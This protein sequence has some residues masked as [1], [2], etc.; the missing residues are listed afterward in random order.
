MKRGVGQG[1]RGAG[2]ATA[3][4]LFFAVGFGAGTVRS[5]ERTW[6]RSEIL[7]IADKEAQTSGYDIERM[8]ISLDIYNS[9]WREHLRTSERSGAIGEIEGKLK[10]RQYWAVYYSPLKERQLG[11]DI[12]VFVDRNTGEILGT[13]RGK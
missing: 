6:T 10:D 13:L 8:G 9:T 12:F 4:L 11:G 7:A 3:V 1:A 2:T 5:E